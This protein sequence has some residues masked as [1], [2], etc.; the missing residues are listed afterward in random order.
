MKDSPLSQANSTSSAPSPTILQTL[1]RTLNTYNTVPKR[2]LNYQVSAEI[3]HLVLQ[4][5]LALPTEDMIS[6]LIS[7]ARYTHYAQN[8]YS[9]IPA[10]S[11]T[12]LIFIQS[13]FREI[14]D[15][16][17]QW[18]GRDRAN[19]EAF[20]RGGGGDKLVQDGV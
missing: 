4:Y 19:F 16:A 18:L 8:R 12:A 7:W 5:L 2:A 11:A 13:Q 9:S 6:E 1:F 20:M 14:L 10:S 15:D 17:L 3:N